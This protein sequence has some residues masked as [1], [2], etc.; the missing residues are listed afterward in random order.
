METRANFVLIGAF[1]L[2]GFAVL[3]LFLM[4]FARIELDRQYDYY[5]TDFPSVSGLSSA[6]SVRFAGLPV[7]QVVDVSLSPDQSGRVR[8]R[9]EVAADTPVRTSSVATIESQGVT[10]VSYV[11]LSAGDPRDPLLSATSA[12]QVPQIPAGRSALQTLTEGAPEII[13]ELLS[14]S[15]QLGEILG[16]ANQARIATTLANIEAAS[17]ELGR[18]LE[19]FSTV[20]ET[21]ATS[22]EEIAGFT[23]RLEG[24]AESAETA[25]ASVTELADRAQATLDTGD[26]ALVSGRAALDAAELFVR[27]DLPVLADD[28]A[29]AATGIRQQVDEIGATAQVALDEIRRTGALAA[30][31]LAEA[32]ATVAAADRVLGD[33]SRTL[34][35][36]DGAAQRFDSFLAVDG[37]ALVAD[38]RGLLADAGRMAD[39]AALIAETDL[40]DLVAAI[41]SATGTAESVL[42]QV[43]TDLGAAAGRIDGLSN[44]AS[45]ALDAVT[46]TFRN[47]NGTLARLDAALET[48]D[49]ALAAAD[50]A[51]VSADRVLRED[52][53]AMTATLRETLSQIDGA[54]AQIAEDIPVI[55][56]ELRQTAE[57]ANAAFGEVES[58]AASLGPPL[59]V[60]ADRGLPQYATLAE[61]MRQL[62]RSL[63]RL[64]T[65]IERDPARYFLGR[66]APVFRR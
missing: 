33:A 55:S 64:V 39:A 35:S 49:A 48:G 52:I 63:D 19:S 16:A 36:V 30:D 58:T 43:G 22:A 44:D 29:A 41:R 13:D 53:G 59:R 25:L 65:R 27:Q 18:S 17:G 23:G 28:L 32:E 2:A 62:V 46:E 15:R 7:G 42:A 3:L 20:S 10:G 6:S 51:F 9:I 57:R 31:R 60:F 5:D 14:V 1:T 54:L 11:G 8:V 34:A 26:A 45:E 21:I 12:D 4:W 61:E 56:S 50:R 66:E 24:V 38:A 47:A 40:P 37:A